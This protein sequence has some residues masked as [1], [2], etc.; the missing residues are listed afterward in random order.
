MTNNLLAVTRQIVDNGNLYHGVSTGLLLKCC[1]GCIYQYLCS[2]GGIVN[3]HIELEELI[4]RLTA[5][6]L[7]NQI[8]SVTYIV[9]FINT[10]HLENMCLVT[11]KIGVGLDGGCYCL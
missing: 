10:I 7:A 9:Q 2:K 5:Y 1:T 6:T 8:Y 4:V 3:L 11:G